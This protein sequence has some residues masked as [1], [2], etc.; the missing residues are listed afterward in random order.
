MG[1]SCQYVP[2]YMAALMMAPVNLRPAKE[3]LLRSA[4]KIDLLIHPLVQQGYF[5]LLLYTSIL[6]CRDAPK[7]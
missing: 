6:R 3:C 5:L 1:E 2:I 4:F 7:D